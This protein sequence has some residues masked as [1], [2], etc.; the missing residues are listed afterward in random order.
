MYRE[1]KNDISFQFKQQVIYR[2]SIVSY[3]KNG[4]FRFYSIIRKLS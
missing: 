1:A 2:M 3:L 4:S